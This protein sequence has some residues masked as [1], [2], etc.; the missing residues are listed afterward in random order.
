MGRIRDR[1]QCSMQRC[2]RTSKESNVCG[3]CETAWVSVNCC[4]SAMLRTSTPVQ[5]ISGVEGVRI[6]NRLGNKYNDK[7]C[8]LE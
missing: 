7:Y 2:I 1:M 5:R 4:A 6:K 8:D 3:V